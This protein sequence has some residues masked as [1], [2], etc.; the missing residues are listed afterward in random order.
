MSFGPSAIT[1]AHYA[2]HP[3]SLFVLNIVTQTDLGLLDLYHGAI[4]LFLEIDGVLGRFC[5]PVL[6]VWRVD[7]L[8]GIHPPIRWF[9]MIP[10]DG[11]TCDDGKA[12]I[13]LVS[14]QSHVG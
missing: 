9:G 3:S 11:E 4:I 12:T 10:D 14:K 1:R 6:L 8:D 7:E 2:I 13:I 5:L